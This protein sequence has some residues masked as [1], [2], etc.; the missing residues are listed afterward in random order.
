MPLDYDVYVH[1]SYDTVAILPRD[2]ML[3]LFTDNSE[4]ICFFS[5]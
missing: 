2:A 1:I 4:L 5:F 3:E